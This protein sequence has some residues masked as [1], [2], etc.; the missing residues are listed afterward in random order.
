LV[1]RPGNNS[2][3]IWSDLDET[4]IIEA[5]QQKPTCE[6]G[7]V[8]VKLSGK[9]V[10]NNNQNLTYFLEPLSLTNVSV[11]IPIA[12]VVKEDIGVSYTCS[13]SSTSKMKRVAELW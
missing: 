8:T 7:D 9:S 4:P 2:Y 12:E 1:L 3:F 6:T 10:L 11:T 13:N 5:L